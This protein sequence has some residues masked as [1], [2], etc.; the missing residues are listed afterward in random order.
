MSELNDLFREL[1][2]ENTTFITNKKVISEID[3]LVKSEKKEIKEDRII[4]D[5]ENLNELKDIWTDIKY[6][7]EL[8][9]K[10]FQSP[11]KYHSIE[12]VEIMDS[13]KEGLDKIDGLITRK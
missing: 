13:I 10:M 7:V 3:V 5:D 6:Q 2:K 4:I 12:L 11:H 8:A 9:E 1:I